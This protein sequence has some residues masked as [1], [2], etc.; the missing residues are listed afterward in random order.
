MTTLDSIKIK[1]PNDS[2][3]LLNKSAFLT[4]TTTDSEGNSFGDKRILRKE[5][6]DYGLKNIEI[7]N[8]YSTI[9]IS[10]KI[11]KSD[12]HRSICLNTLDHVLFEINKGQVVELNANSLDTADVLRCDT[13][14]NIKVEDIKESIE[15]LQL[16][17]SNT[18]FK[19]DEYK[20]ANNRGIT[21]T[22]R[23][24]TYKNRQIYYDKTTELNQ[25]K[26]KNFV[27]DSG[28]KVFNDFKNTLRVEQNLTSLDRIRKAFKTTNKLNDVLTSKENPNYERH[29]VITKFA[30]QVS[31]FN[32]FQGKKIQD[33]V[34][35]K[36]LEG[37]IL[38]CN[39]SLELAED[40]LNSLEA[41]RMTKY[42]YRKKL[43]Y[44]YSDILSQKSRQ[45]TPYHATLT[46]IG[47]LLKVA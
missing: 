4:Q 45:I 46:H 13:T 31:I 37:I 2:F 47:E 24:K 16:G 8:D 22:G 41:S 18:G 35:Y 27:K 5:F 11:L 39:N 17:K 7:H 10:A 14:K 43:N 9:E 34:L 1:C 29:K 42:T 36:G 21:F 12:Y 44:V 6:K 15:A 25:A 28:Y 26:N 30:N 40:F 33:V 3:R 23:Q 20:R 32:Q 38:A 19:V